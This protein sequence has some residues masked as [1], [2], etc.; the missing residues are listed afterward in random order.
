[1]GINKYHIYFYMVVREGHWLSNRFKGDDLK[2]YV[3]TMMQPVG[4]NISAGSCVVHPY[5]KKQ[6]KYSSCSCEQYHPFTTRLGETRLEE[7]PVYY[8][9]RRT[10]YLL[11]DWE[12]HPFTTRLEGLPIYYQ[13]GRT[14]RLLPD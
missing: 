7:L 12:N 5:H 11:P 6:G 4:A 8:Q 13:T 3:E 9:T 14:T 2:Q 10:T 1:M